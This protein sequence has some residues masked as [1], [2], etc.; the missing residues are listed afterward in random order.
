MSVP[1]AKLVASASERY[2]ALFQTQS[3]SPALGA[4]RTAALESFCATGFPTQ[5]DEAW[6]YTNLRR[7][8]SRAF[9][10]CESA[11]AVSSVADSQ[12]M[13]LPGA[14]FVLIN[15]RNLPHLSGSMPQPPGVTAVNL[16]HWLAS[17]PETAAEFLQRQA[18][19]SAAFEHLNLAFSSDGLVVEL[20][21]DTV[22]ELPLYFLHQWTL[23]ALMSHP[24][25]IVRAGRNSRCVLVEHYVGTAG[26]ESFTNSV[27]TIEAASGANIVHYRVQHESP[28][29]FHVGHTRVG[30]DTHASY[31]QY[32]IAF[33]ASLSRVATAVTLRGEGASAALLG[34]LM[35]GGSQHLDTFTCIEHAAGRT[36]SNELY[37]GIADGRGRAVFRGKVIVRPDA[38]QIDAR[39]SNR[40]L[41]L[42]STAEIDTRPE[43]EIYANDVKCSHGATTG[44]LDATALFYL[45][46]RGLSE[47]QARSALIRAFAEG[48]VGQLQHA[49]VADFLERQLEQRFANLE[50]AP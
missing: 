39:Q 14:R 26:V 47:A 11:A 10:P 2:Q 5:R 15:G 33:G 35:P 12:W 30:L 43:L 6:K 4:L 3:H 44:Q 23:P 18:A 25:I 16:G 38:Q 21:D 22:C 31:T 48:F 7:L 41:L 42:S 24:R 46:S 28:Q 49:P 13:Q 40:N 37:R 17:A 19:P 34:L 27:T 29:S 45:R 9:A 1:A 36:L 20:A 50:V 8:E 32:E